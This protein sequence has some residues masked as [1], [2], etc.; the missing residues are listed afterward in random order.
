MLEQS[1][2]QVLL[3][4][5]RRMRCVLHWAQVFSV[6]SFSPVSVVPAW[7]FSVIKVS[8]PAAR[9]PPASAV[10]SMVVEDVG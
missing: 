7:L 8:K 2:A 3:P 5:C 6:L 1:L 9:T 4:G 10:C